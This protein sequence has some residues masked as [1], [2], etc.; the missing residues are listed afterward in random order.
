MQVLDFMI[1]NVDF[2][3]VLL[4][5]WVYVRCCIGHFSLVLSVSAHI[6]ALGIFLSLSLPIICDLSPPFMLHVW[7]LCG[8]FC[9]VCV[10]NE[11]SQ[12]EY[13]VELCDLPNHRIHIIESRS[14]LC[15]FDLHWSNELFLFSMRLYHRNVG[16]SLTDNYVINWSGIPTEMHTIE[17]IYR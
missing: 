2:N 3:E 13:V 6:F 11:T 1:L 8:H 17:N 15:F 16:L 14:T 5:A 4:N 12:C 7:M 9:Q 10:R